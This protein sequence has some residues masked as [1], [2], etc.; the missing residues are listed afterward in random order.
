MHVVGYMNDAVLDSAN[1]PDVWVNQVSGY[2]PRLRADRPASASG[3][4]RG[5]ATLKTISVD[6]VLRC[7]NCA[8]VGKA[9][10]D[11]RIGAEDRL[12]ADS[13]AMTK[14]LPESS[15]LH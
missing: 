6:P 10:A 12:R 14:T 2:F 11:E 7:G 15:E 8:L 9:L 4:F 1:W 5:K 13:C 3:R